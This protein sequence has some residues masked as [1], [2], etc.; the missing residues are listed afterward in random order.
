[1]KK[2]GLKNS[3]KIVLLVALAVVASSCLEKT[4]NLGTEK[5]ATNKLWQWD[6]TQKSWLYN[7]SL[8]T[9]KPNDFAASVWKKKENAISLRVESLKSLNAFDNAPKAL[10]MKVFQ[11]SDSKA[12]LQAAKSSSGLKHLLVTEQIDPAVVGME[13]RIIL[14]GESQSLTLDR[15]EGARYI[16]IVLGY[17]SLKQD[18]IFRLIPIVTLEDSNPAEKPAEESSFLSSL[19]SS[20]AKQSEVKPLTTGHPAVLKINLLLEANGINKLEVDAR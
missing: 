8:F 16:G 17:G 7:G 13:R 5:E 1:M 11:L 15:L 20:K 2:M 18:K 9:P 19:V 3:V 4:E 6:D 14:P 10:Q 12:F